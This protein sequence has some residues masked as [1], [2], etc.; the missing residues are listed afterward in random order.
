MTTPGCCHRGVMLLP[1]LPLLL[2]LQLALPLLLPP[3]LFERMEARAPT[4]LNRG[5]R[6]GA[7]RI[8]ASGCTWSHQVS[9][10]APNS[11]AWRFRWPPSAAPGR[12]TCALSTLTSLGGV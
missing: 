6:D 7:C 2:L 9:E 4:R 11:L 3:L 8:A 10:D 12:S 5:H 1:L